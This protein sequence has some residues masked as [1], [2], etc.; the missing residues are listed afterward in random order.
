MIKKSNKT[1][2]NKQREMEEFSRKVREFRE[3]QRKAFNYTV[4]EI[5]DIGEESVK[6]ENPELIERK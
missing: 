1:E 4:D 3:A 5:V 6:T 2:K